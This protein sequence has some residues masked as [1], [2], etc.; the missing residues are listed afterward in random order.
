VV[1]HRHHEA[2]ADAPAGD[3]G[4][5]RL[6]GRD[7]DGRHA[8]PQL[9]QIGHIGAGRKGA[10]AGACEDRNALRRTI[11]RGKRLLQFNGDGLVDR[12]QLLRPVDADDRDRPPLL[13]ADDAHAYSPL[14]ELRP[15]TLA[16]PAKKAEFAQTLWITRLYNLKHTFGSPRPYIPD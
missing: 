12:V 10:A 6:V 11:E 9:G 2:A 16:Q 15:A 1:H 3:R 8:A 4:D 14:L 5:N 7:P 13:D